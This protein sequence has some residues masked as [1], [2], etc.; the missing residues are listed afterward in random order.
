MSTAQARSVPR[1]GPVGLSTV[2]LKGGR[3]GFKL[4]LSSLVDP[5]RWSASRIYEV[6]MLSMLVGEVPPSG[7]CSPSG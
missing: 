2:R 6:I 7:S 4:S 1:L 5:F 3:V